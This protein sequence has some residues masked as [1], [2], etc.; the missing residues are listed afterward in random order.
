MLSRK[1][2]FNQAGRPGCDGAREATKSLVITPH[3]EKDRGGTFLT[4]LLLSSDQRAELAGHSMRLCL[5]LGSSFSDLLWKC[6]EKV[7]SN[8]DDRD[9]TLHR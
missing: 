6:S 1:S 2:E 4:R 5:V 7:T 3:F 9:R 8:R